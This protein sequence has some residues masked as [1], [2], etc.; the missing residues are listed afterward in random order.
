MALPT[1]EASEEMDEADAKGL[2]VAE[3]L[4][5][6]KEAGGFSAPT[7]LPSLS[8]RDFTRLAKPII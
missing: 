8:L 7:P 6:A 5:A 1:F 4:K 3:G 2:V